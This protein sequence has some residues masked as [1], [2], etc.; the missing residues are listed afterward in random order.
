[1]NFVALPVKVGLFCA[2]VEQSVKISWN[3]GR[4]EGV[5]FLEVLTS[6]TSPHPSSHARH[7]FKF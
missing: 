4:G 3:I 5:F 2:S 6:E 1:M 7:F